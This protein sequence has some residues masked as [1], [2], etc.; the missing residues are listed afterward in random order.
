[1]RTADAAPDVRGAVSIA[2]D[3]ATPAADPDPCLPP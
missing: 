1:M 2:P 3:D